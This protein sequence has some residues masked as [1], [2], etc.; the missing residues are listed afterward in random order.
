MS[1]GHEAYDAELTAVAYVSAER[2]ERGKD[3][4]V[5]TDS[6]ATMTRVISDAPGPGQDLAIRI[7]DLAQEIV[8]RGNT[9]IV[10]R[11]PAH[12]GVEENEQADQRAREAAALPLP[13]NTTR[14]Y[15]LASL[16]RRATERATASWRTDIENRNAGRRT[17]RLSTASS[18]PNLR[19]RL[20]RAAKSVA[21]RFFQLLSGHAMMAAFL[22]EKWGWTD[23]DRWWC[24]R[25]RQSREQ[26]AWVARELMQFDWG[27]RASDFENKNAAKSSALGDGSDDAFKPM[28]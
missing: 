3:Y 22:R 4:T 7:I 13:R 14:Y 12:R 24:E 17:F 20:R 19:P 28:S 6:V 10:R 1:T 27:R 23:S 16:R 15:S 11:T 18:R 21:A 5:F 26:P 25:G 9:V 2:G 8:S